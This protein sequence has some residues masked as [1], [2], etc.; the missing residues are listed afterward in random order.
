MSSDTLPPAE[1]ES[2]SEM[3]DPATANGRENLELQPDGQAV[4]SIVGEVA[5][6]KAVE[7]VRSGT[8]DPGEAEQK[9]REWAEEN[10]KRTRR[11]RLDLQ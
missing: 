3:Y 1:V 7:A 11:H 5:L 8:G 10:N 2:T 9:L 4:S 6:E